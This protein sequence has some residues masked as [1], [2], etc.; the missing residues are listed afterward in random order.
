RQV[1]QD[2]L[3]DAVVRGVRTGQ[4]AADETPA[5][6]GPR[7]AATDPAV[8]LATLRDALVGRQRV[9]IGYVD[10]GGRTE[11][12]VVEP[13]SVEGGRVTAFDHGLDEVRDFSVHRITGVAPADEPA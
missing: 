7:L 13:L 4:R 3:L 6:T 9:W 11:R 1:L 2:A 5:P 12:R 10:A 8:T